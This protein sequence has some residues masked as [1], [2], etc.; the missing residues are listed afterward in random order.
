MGLIKNIF[1]QGYSYLF[2]PGVLN[3]LVHA[4]P[5]IKI[6]PSEYPQIRIIC[7]SC[8][9][10]SKILPKRASFE[11]FFN[12]CIPPVTFARTPRGTRTPG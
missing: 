10:K 6:V 8:T 12:F 11:H 7:P 9:P 5:Q 2:R 4:Y 3:L 1:F